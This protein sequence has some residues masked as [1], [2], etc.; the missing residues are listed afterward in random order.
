MQMKSSYFS[1]FLISAIGFFIGGISAAYLHHQW[2]YGP[3]IKAF[4]D[5]PSANLAYAYFS[6]I[7]QLLPYLVSGLFAGFISALGA[8]TLPKITVRLIG[9]V[10]LYGCLA[11][12]SL[13]LASVGYI[14][15]AF[16]AFAITCFFLWSYSKISD[17]EIFFW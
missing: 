11:F 8:I 16:G 12:R 17:R 5:P 3:L 6:G 1:D 7:F 2:Y 4:G 15:T 10:L 9:P 14:P 13:T